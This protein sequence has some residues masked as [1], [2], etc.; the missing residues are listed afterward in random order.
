MLQ[1]LSS[2]AVVIGALMVKQNIDT[3]QLDS[4]SLLFQYYHWNWGKTVNMK[5]A[6]LNLHCFVS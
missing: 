6:D 4:Y 5:P 2:A 1:N 3:D